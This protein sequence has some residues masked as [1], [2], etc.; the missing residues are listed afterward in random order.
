MSFLYLLT[1]LAV[2]LLCGCAAG[3]GI[4]TDSVLR[5]HGRLPRLLLRRPCLV[6]RRRR[7]ALA[8]RD[9]PVLSVDAGGPRRHPVRPAT[10]GAGG[11]GRVGRA[12]RGAGPPRRRRR[13]PAVLGR[14]AARRQG[15]LRR[16]HRRRAAAPRTAGR[17]RRRQHAV[18]TRVERSTSS[19]AA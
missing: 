7:D 12:R 18:Q 1:L 3:T 4:T 5:Q 13:L 2:L 6:V 11:P 8:P 19:L 9:P 15:R 17:G 14:A 10:G 16:R